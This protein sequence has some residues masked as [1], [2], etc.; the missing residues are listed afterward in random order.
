MF[1]VLSYLPLFIVR[2]L[3]KQMSNQVNV[4]VTNVRGSSNSYSYKGRE[5]TR[6]I[7]F[8]P[9][10]N[11]VPVGIAVSSL[12]GLVNITI[13]S[14]PSVIKDPVKFIEFVHEEIDAM[15]QDTIK[16]KDQ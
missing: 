4:V 16:K 2:P 6:I 12:A 14:D 15:R 10:P 11:P 3:F 1:L 8:I 9:P 13:K 5:V 7:G